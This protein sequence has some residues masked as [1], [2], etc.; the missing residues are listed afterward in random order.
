MSVPTLKI[1]GVEIALQ[2]FPAAQSYGPL[3]G[4]TVHRM[5]NG[6]AVKQQ[7]WRKLTTTI[8]GDGWAPTALAGVDWSAPVEILC[9]QPR[10][11]HSATVNATLPAARRSDLVVNVIALAVVG[12][13]LVPT[14]VSVLVNAATATAVAG[15][16]SYQFMYYPKL[17]CYSSG[18]EESLDTAGAA[19]AWSL[20]AEEI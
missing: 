16:T 18:P 6:A 13:E 15:A 14:P 4:A 11:L 12:N 3:E 2:T 5:L 10:A 17:S 7:H 1:A 20:E 9:M 19:Y 8:S